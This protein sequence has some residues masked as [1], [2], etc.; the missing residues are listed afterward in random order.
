MGQAI[1]ERL[2]NGGH[3]VHRVEPIDGGTRINCSNSVRPTRPSRSGEPVAST[4]RELT[5]LLGDSPMVAPGIRNRFRTVLEA[6]GPT[7]WTT[8]LGA[9]D[10]RLAT[11]LVTANA[12]T[13]LHLALGS[14]SVPGGS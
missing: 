10:A 13:Q 14:G 6:S 12:A 1:S 7:W 2:L 5:D 9:K 11:E 8:E 3:A 4:T